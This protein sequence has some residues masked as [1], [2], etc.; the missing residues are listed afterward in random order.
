MLC[1]VSHLNFTLHINLLPVSQTYYSDENLRL[2]LSF[3][4]PG[5][6]CIIED[7]TTVLNNTITFVWEST[8]GDQKTNIIGYVLELSGDNGANFKVCSEL[9][10]VIPAKCNSSF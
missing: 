9:A 7:K 5:A 4:V 2:F 1:S 8:V 3:S 10:N 6:P